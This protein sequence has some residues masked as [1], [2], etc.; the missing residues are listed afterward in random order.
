MEDTLDVKE[1]PGTGKVFAV[2][3]CMDLP[4]PKVA[5]L[6]GAEGASVAKQVMA[7]AAG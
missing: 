7:S 4:V 2:G 1:A 3:D 5:F 6:A